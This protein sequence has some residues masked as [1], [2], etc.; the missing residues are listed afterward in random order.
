MKERL[1]K[2]EKQESELND[3]ITQMSAFMYSSQFSNLDWEEIH[4]IQMEYGV[5]I[6]HR[7]II[8]L[9]IKLLINAIEKQEGRKQ[10]LVG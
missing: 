8:M 4:L 9:R 1:S 3:K 7:N 2:L 10:Q 5:L 6:T